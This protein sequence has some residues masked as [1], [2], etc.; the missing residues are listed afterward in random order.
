MTHRILALLAAVVLLFGGCRRTVVS[1]QQFDIAA[2]RAQASAPAQRQEQSEEPLTTLSLAYSVSDSLNPFLMKT[3]MNRM[4]IPLLYDSLTGVD[5]TWRP[6]NILA[7]EI[8]VENKLCTVKLRSG[9]VFSDGSPLT[10]KDVIYSITTAMASDTDWKTTLQ[11]ISGCS[12][13]DDG[14]VEIRLYSSDADFAALLSFPIVKEG[15]AADDYPVGISKYFVSGTWGGSGVTLA[16]NPIYWNP[17]SVGSV[18]TIR[19]ANVS[20]PDALSFSLRTG[21]IDLM[22]SDLSD[23]DFAFSAASGVPVSLNS[24]VYIGVNGNRGLLS[25]A[26]FRQALSL[27][28]NRDELVAKAY[29]THARAT[30]YPFN[31][32]FYRMEE[33]EL[34][35]PRELARAE[36]LL[37]GMGLTQKDEN[38]Y[39]LRNGQPVTLRLLVNSEN[40]CRNAAATLLA[41]QLRQLGVQVTVESQSFTQYQASLSRRDYDLYIGET[42][43]MDNMDFSVLLSGGALSYSTPYIES[44]SELYGSYR[45]T[46]A[47]IGTFCEAFAEQSP[48]IPLVF[49]QGQVSF[50]RSFDAQIVATEQNLFYNLSEW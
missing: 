43:L 19:L 33:L 21:D 9:I 30:L 48:F 34:S 28:I 44:L 32:E 16:R 45:S 18:E 7:E 12:V 25:E 38:G 23:G 47:G 50:N 15:T 10:G 29:L 35:T 41:E 1:D 5:K 20:D 46:G 49:R 8:T 39:R 6:Q 31:P 11:N 13:N 27:A 42:R 3:Q 22:Y 14:A 24:L 4:L 26:Q 37:A 2:Q 40:A 36:E 17:Q